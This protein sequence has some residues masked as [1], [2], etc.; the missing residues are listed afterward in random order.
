MTDFLDPSIDR[1][2]FLRMS[3]AVGTLA[4]GNFPVPG[5][6]PWEGVEDRQLDSRDFC[7]SV[8]DS[9]PRSLASTGALT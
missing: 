4:T 6:T 7:L 5:G 3:A 9:M 1:R 2:E 8:Y